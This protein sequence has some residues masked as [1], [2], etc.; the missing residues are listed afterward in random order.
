M[1]LK[2]KPAPDSMIGSGTKPMGST[3]LPNQTDN[4]TMTEI[5]RIKQK[6]RMKKLRELQSLA[7]RV[8]VDKDGKRTFLRFSALQRAEHYILIVSFGT[9][10]FTGLLQTFSEITLIGLFIQILGGIEGLRSIH[11]LVAVILIL[12][13]IYHLVQILMMWTIKRERGGMWP[14]FKDFTNLV[15][16]ILFNMGLA[17]EKP[18]SDHYSIEE[19]LEYWAMLWG[20]PLMI[21]T[22][23]ILWF[24]VLITKYFPGVLIPISLTIHRWEAILAALA[25]LTWHMYHTN[26]RVVNRSIFTGKMSEEEMQHEHFLEYKRIL[27]AYEFMQKNTPSSD[28]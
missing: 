26:I 16:Q 14:Y 10:V 6:A 24:P 5:E 17:K 22:G 23:L 21:L 28:G 15:Q 25:I 19:K 3:V 13:S 4:Q 18:K 12:Q 1:S 8:I 2:S 7:E 11:H 27:A 20:T 9:L